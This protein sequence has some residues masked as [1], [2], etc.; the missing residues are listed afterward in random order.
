MAF[1][2]VLVGMGLT[3]VLG[4][5]FMFWG[6][7][8]SFPRKVYYHLFASIFFFFLGQLFLMGYAADAVAVEP[9]SYA[10]WMLGIVNFIFFILSGVQ[11]FRVI[12]QR[13]KYG[14]DEE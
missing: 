3:F 8:E 1:E 13:R 9:I 11:G 7:E 12:N 6:F 5:I 2:T 4:F 10:F 14:D